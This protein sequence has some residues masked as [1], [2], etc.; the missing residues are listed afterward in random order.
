MP[1]IYLVPITPAAEEWI[2]PVRREVEKTFGMKA[3]EA[4]G[5]MDIREAYDHTR[6]QYH[7]SKLLL[8]LLRG[9]PDDALK[10]LGIADVDLFIPILTFVFGEAQL[11]GAGAVVSLHRLNNK[12]YGLPEDP[13]LL[14]DRLVKESVHELGH[15]FGLTHCGHRECVMA[16]STYAEDIDQ[17]LQDLCIHCRDRLIS[18]GI[19]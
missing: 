15:T 17:K 1:Y 8:Q 10:I 6:R 9:A 2:E 7:S 4:R 12:F 16:S 18:L 14:A 11:S 19:L 3:R 13:F 5:S